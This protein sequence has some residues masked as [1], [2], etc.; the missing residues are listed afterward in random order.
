MVPLSS[1]ETQPELWNLSANV[2]LQT[3]PLTFGTTTTG[4]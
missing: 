2:R 3:P 4:R 1:K